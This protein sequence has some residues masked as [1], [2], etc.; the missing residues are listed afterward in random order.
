MLSSKCFYCL[1]LSSFCSGLFDFVESFLGFSCIFCFFLFFFVEEFF[2]LLGLLLFYPIFMPFDS[3][4]SF[5]F[6]ELGLS[7]FHFGNGFCDGFSLSFGL[8]LL[9]SI[10]LRLLFGFSCFSL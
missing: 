4:N 2:S 8:G 3:L 10:K 6:F 5:F 1:F 7:F 9:F